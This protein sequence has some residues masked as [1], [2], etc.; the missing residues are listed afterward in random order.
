MIEH[1]PFHPHLIRETK[2]WLGKAGIAYFKML[3]EKNAFIEVHLT[4]G[5]QVRNFMRQSGQ[6]EEW[7]AHDL[8]NNWIELIKECIKD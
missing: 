1:R 4:D 3:N 7:D 6:C 2:K 5:M 8:D